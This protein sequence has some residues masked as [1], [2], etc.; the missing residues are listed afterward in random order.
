V[1]EEATKPDLIKC[2]IGD[3]EGVDTALDIEVEG[4]QV[5]SRE[6][7]VFQCDIIDGNLLLQGDVVCHQIDELPVL[8][9]SNARST[10]LG[11]LWSKVRGVHSHTWNQYTLLVVGLQVA[12]QRFQRLAV[13]LL[14]QCMTLILI[15]LT[16]GGGDYV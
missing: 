4:T 1:S 9:K 15:L 13:A 5:A 12:S 11:S 10:C 8:S 6:G 14:S 3:R 2:A 16:R 7:Q